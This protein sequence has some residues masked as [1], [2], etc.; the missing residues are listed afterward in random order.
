MGTRLDVDQETIAIAAGGIG[1]PNHVRLCD[2]MDCSTAGLPVPHHLPEFAQVHVHCIG[3]VIQ[4]IQS[5]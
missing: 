4:P 5:I 2:P 3:D 1:S